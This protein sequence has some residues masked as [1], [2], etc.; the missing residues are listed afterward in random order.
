MSASP[1]RVIVFDELL[2][3][4][5]SLRAQART[6]G[7]VGG[8]ID[9]DVGGLP[10]EAQELVEDLRGIGRAIERGAER[11]VK[12]AAEF[13]QTAADALGLD[14]KWLELA[15]G[16]AR[17][18]VLPPG[19]YGPLGAV[20]WAGGRAAF[21]ASQ[22][23]ALLRHKGGYRPWV[24]DPAKRWPKYLSGPSIHPL[25]GKWADRFA[26]G[27]TIA[28]SGFTFADAFSRRMKE[29]QDATRAVAGAGG[30][31]ATAFGCAKTGA[32]I[33]SKVPGG[34]TKVAGAVGGGVLGAAGCT[35]WGRSVGDFAADRG[36]EIEKRVPEPVKDVIGGAAKGINDGIKKLD[37]YDNLR[38]LAGALRP[39][40]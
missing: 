30:E 34:W 38:G 25:F 26:K 14:R 15:W 6:V 11:L 18:Q 29:G 16:T 7:E 3:L 40:G 28:G 35:K 36:E 27:G 10:P 5:E 23:A 9:I 12:I 2:G 17:S 22:A 21:G 1:T 4:D 33:G 20:P 32:K 24:T 13:G 8:G 31:T 19:G 37:P 39:G